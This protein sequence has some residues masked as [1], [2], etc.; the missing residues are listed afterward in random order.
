VLKHVYITERLQPPTSLGSV[1][2]TYATLSGRARSVGYWREVVKSGEWARLSVYAVKAYGILK[3]R[4]FCFSPR[5]K[6]IERGIQ[7]GEIVG[8]RSIVGYNVQ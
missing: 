4:L 5:Q 8:R 6:G 7:I 1:L 2:G 3:C